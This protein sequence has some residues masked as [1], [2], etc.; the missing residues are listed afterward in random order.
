MGYFA[1]DY[2]KYSEPRL[3]LTA[4][5]DGNFNDVDLM[6]FDKV[7]AFDHV[8]EEIILI[9]NMNTHDPEAG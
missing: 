1:Y 3:E 7:I 4:A 6:L 2:A 5:E 9:F 8:K